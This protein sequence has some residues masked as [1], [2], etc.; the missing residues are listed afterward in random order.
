MTQR[1]LDWATA[2][3]IAVGVCWMSG[4]LAAGAHAQGD[5]NQASCPASTELADRKSVV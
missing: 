2:T 5:A 1:G 4:V 3:L